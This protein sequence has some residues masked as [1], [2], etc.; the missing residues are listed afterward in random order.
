M[1]PTLGFHQLF[2]LSWYRDSIILMAV[3]IACYKTKAISIDK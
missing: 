3:A 2:C 1:M